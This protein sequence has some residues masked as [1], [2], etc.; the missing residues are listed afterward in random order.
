[1][2]HSL[3]KA[4]KKMRYARTEVER[5]AEET[6]IFADIYCD[7][8][9]AYPANPP[10]NKRTSSSTQQ[11]L[12]TW[13]KDAVRRLKKLLSRVQA[14]NEDSGYLSFDAW[15]AR[16]RWHLTE[17][18]VKC[19]RAS[20]DAA[21]ESINCFRNIRTI[22]HLFELLWK[23]ETAVNEERR[24]ELE[25]QHG[26]NVERA[27]NELHVTLCHTMSMELTSTGNTAVVKGTG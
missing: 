24:Q 14:L 22:E 9:K 11:Y 26:A 20:L 25:V 18:A 4:I 10:N 13:T 7:F 19:L 23:L 17:S 8:M 2:S 16:H 5:L 3:K 15:K 12:K 27:K 6:E 21:S 1:M